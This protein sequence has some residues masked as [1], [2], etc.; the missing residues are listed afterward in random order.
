MPRNPSSTTLKG[1]IAVCF[2]SI[3]IGY[4]AI[5]ASLASARTRA[6]KLAGTAFSGSRSSATACASRSLRS[7]CGF[8]LRLVLT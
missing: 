8:K 5:A 7:K 1:A 4:G 3:A 6:A 2:Q